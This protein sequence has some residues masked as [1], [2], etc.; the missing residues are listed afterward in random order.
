MSVLCFQFNGKRR[1]DNN[2]IL[3]QLPCF[4]AC[5]LQLLWFTL[6]HSHQLY[7][8]IVIIKVLTES[9][10]T[11]DEENIFSSWRKEEKGIV[12]SLSSSSNKCFSRAS[13]FLPSVHSDGQTNCKRPTFFSFCFPV[14]VCL[15][16]YAINGKQWIVPRRKKE[17]MIRKRRE[18]DGMWRWT[19]DTEWFQY[20]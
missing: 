7:I 15:N 14:S 16:H 11:R 19:S 9:N 20:K 13:L 8:A 4:V 5:L 2:F 12:A 17:G 6:S 1:I 10:E 3:V 18:R